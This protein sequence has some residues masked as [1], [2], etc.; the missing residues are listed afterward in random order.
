ML[1]QGYTLQSE[2]LGET[3][4]I[5]VYVPPGYA[6]GSAAYPVL[7]LIDGGVEQR[8]RTDGFDA[9]IGEPLAGLFVAE[10]F[11]RQPDLFDGYISVDPS[12]W[13]DNA[14]LDLQA[15]A[16]DGVSF[17]Y[18]VMDDEEHSTIYH[19]AARD[20]LRVVFANSASGE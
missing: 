9:V 4:Q 13:W 11:L 16:G 14:A 7:Y 2:V 8:Y 3:R 6:T 1:G 17:N 15:R 20:A 18:E 10:T 12:L 5:N 19:R